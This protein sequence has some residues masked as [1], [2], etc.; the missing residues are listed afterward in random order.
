M[1]RALNHNDCGWT[2]HTHCLR[3]LIGF[4]QISQV[5]L[6]M[7]GRSGPV[8]SLD[9]LL[10]WLWANPSVAYLGGGGTGRCPPPFGLNTNFLNTLNPDP[11]FSGEGTP[12]PHTPPHW[13]LRRLEPRVFGS[14]PLHKILNT[15]LQSVVMFLTDCPQSPSEL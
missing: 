4:V 13:R 8:D 1:T 3:T 10:P 9:Q 11:F 5:T 15:P 7:V 6:V 12:P 2:R 14:A